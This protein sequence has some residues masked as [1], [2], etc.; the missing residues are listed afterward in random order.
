M[1]KKRDAE[2]SLELLLDTM[3]NTFGGVMFIA[4]ALIVV[5]SIVSKIKTPET[6]D[7]AA[8]QQRLEQLQKELEK[9]KSSNAARAQ[10]LE[11]LKNDPRR[12]LL[13]EIILLET[14]LQEQERRQIQLNTAVTA[15][16]KKNQLCQQ[17]QTLQQKELLKNEQEKQVV[18]VQHEQL[19][20]Q[21]KQLQE[22]LKKIVSGHIMF[23]TLV[24][25]DAAPYYL[26]VFNNRIWR[27]G[28]EKIG[29]CPHDDVEFTED[30]NKV[31]C[32]IDKSVRGAPLLRDGHIS[33]EAK[34]LLNE[35]PRNRFPDFSLHSN[36]VADFFLFREELKK[37][38][39]SHG[40]NISFE[41]HNEKFIYVYT[42]EN[43]KYDAYK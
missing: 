37:G 33:P 21:I 30:G 29:N 2:S 7:P 25:S 32:Q 41:F 9:L 27:I 17:Q 35:I 19:K 31:V 36:S 18:I 11:A 13:K 38:N 16:V 40:I 22:E 39:I 5:L 14:Q 24:S 15:L 8:T 28:P 6:S 12:E 43:V 26:I 10:M 1:K 42:S 3:C 20:K 34:K 23:K 4:I